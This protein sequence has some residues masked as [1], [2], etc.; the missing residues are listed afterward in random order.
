MKMLFPGDHG[1]AICE[2]CGPITTTYHYRDVPLSDSGKV[3]KD[4]LVGECDKC[5]SVASIP[6]QSTPAIKLEK[7]KATQSIEAVLPAPYLEALD[8]AAFKISNSATTEMRKYLVLI[9]LQKH[10]ESKAKPSDWTAF[11][12][13][14]AKSI[15]LPT[16]RLSIKVSPKIERDF[17]LMANIFSMSKTNTLKSIINDIKE[18]ILDKG[19]V[20]PEIQM[21]AKMAL[22]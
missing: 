17:I 4:I 16:K 6:A 15:K 8:M 13:T 1:K 20:S 2:H 19:I 10:L 3:V 5:H 21:I 22:A 7:E 11:E 14:F 9:Y 12:M 18:D